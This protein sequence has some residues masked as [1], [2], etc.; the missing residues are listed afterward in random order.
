MKNFSLIALTTLL[1]SA[2]AF[3]TTLSCKVV[4]TKT[5]VDQADLN[6][7]E[8]YT[9]LNKFLSAKSAIIEVNA[10]KATLSLFDKTDVA[11]TLP[12]S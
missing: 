9:D 7:G 3:A 4:G 8:T 1:L 2:D 11:I 10:Q 12:L 5:E 6:D